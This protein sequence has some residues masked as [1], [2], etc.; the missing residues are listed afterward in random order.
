MPI[1]NYA[2]YFSLAH[3]HILNKNF[4][5]IFPMDLTI[6][7]YKLLVRYFPKQN[8]HVYFLLFLY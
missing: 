2:I 5:Y 7:T 8:K 1:E 6:N 3:F 4:Y